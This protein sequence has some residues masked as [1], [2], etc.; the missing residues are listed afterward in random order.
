MKARINDIEMVFD[1]E[2]NG[3]PVLLIHGFPLN[4][5]MWKPQVAALAAADYRVITPD[6]RGFGETPA[7]EAA[8]TGDMDTLADDLVALL[9][10]LH[11][12]QAVIGGMSMGGYVLL[13][14]LARHRDRIKAA[15]FLVTRANSD[16]EGGRAKRNHLIAEVEAGRPTAVADAFIQVLFAEETSERNP[17]LVAE[18]Y[19]WLAATDPAGLLLGLRSIRD[20]VDST[21]LLSELILPALVIGAMQDRTLPMENSRE[22]AAAIPGASLDLI[23]QAGHMA[24]LERPDEFN[25]SLLNFLGSLS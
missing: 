19:R 5:S 10:H 25:Q 11:I 23:D 22:L 13:N 15:C 1:E 20:R 4:R 8:T 2:G 18:V 24:N 12:E 14:L 6:M 17:E 21:S 7:G 9:D 3:M 16:D